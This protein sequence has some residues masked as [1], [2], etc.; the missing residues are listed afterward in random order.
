[1]LT[2]PRYNI[3]MCYWNDRNYSRAEEKL[4]EIQNKHPKYR[5]EEISDMI[6]EASGYK[7]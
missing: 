1:M 4:R 3:A 7:Y 6:I 2:S 5:P